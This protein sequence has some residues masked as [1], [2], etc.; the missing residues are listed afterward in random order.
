MEDVK[1][2]AGVAVALTIRLVAGPWVKPTPDTYVRY[3]SGPPDGEGKLPEAAMVKK[4]Y[5]PWPFRHRWEW[6]AGDPY[7]K[8]W[9]E[10]G[11]EKGDDPAAAM[12]A[13]DKALLGIV[14]EIEAGGT[15]WALT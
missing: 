9:M 7:G 13:A 8:E 6:Y 5:M 11:E 1:M 4:K 10:E 15:A 14:A 2:L 3:W 12:A